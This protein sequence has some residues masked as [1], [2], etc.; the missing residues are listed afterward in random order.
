MHKKYTLS[1]QLDNLTNLSYE[2]A[3]L[4]MA[5][6]SVNMLSYLL[7]KS[8]FIRQIEIQGYAKML[9]LL[10]TSPTIFPIHSMSWPFCLWLS[11]Q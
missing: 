7:K 11:V 10:P 5:P 3:I 2:L 9:Y 8:Y 4:S 1:S 6:S